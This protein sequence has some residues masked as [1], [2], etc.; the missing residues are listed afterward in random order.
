MV[1]VLAIHATG[2]YEYRFLQHHN[3]LSQDFLSVV[4]NQMARFSVPVFVA[5]SGFGLT[6][7]YGTLAKETTLQDLK[8]PLP[9]FYRDRI[10]KIGI[11][12]LVWT[13]IILFLKDRLAGPYDKDFFQS[14]L[15]YLYKRGAD[16]HF[17]FFHIIFEC[18]VVFPFLAMFLA[19]FKK[20]RIPALALS[21]LVQFYVSSPS[22][23]W[24]SEW[25]GPPFLFSAF[26]LYWQFPLVLGVTAALRKLEKPAPILSA[27]ARW[28]TLL[29][30]ILAAGICI[31]EY[32]YWSYERSNPGDFNH[33]TRISVM[34]YAA[35]IF[36][37]FLEWPEKDRS[38]EK[39]RTAAKEQ[40]KGE[41]NRKHEVEGKNEM[42]KEDRMATGEKPRRILSYLAGL[43]FFVFIVHTGILRVLKPYLPDWMLLVLVA[44]LLTSFL[45][46]LVV[47]ALISWPWLR[48]ILALEK[49]TAPWAVPGRRKPDPANRQ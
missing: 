37:L 1:L 8:V 49:T 44:L 11:P 13:V 33:F 32:I 16:Y 36:L 9:S 24:F 21:A 31:L 12:F 5:L 38:P 22:H 41:E 18:Y 40:N 25:P 30:T 14:M 39:S 6:I 45:L 2:P 10:I 19:R 4:L 47:D 23:I 15:P 17:Y 46:A 28:W 35:L 7:K 42:A 29:L 48:T 26:L 34:T 27:S 3:F 43:T 20:L